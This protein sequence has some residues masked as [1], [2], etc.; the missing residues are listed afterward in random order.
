[1][2]GRYTL[3]GTRVFAAFG[4][5][6]P[7]GFE[8][9]YNIAPG[10]DCWVLTREDAW[11]ARRMRW[12]LVPHWAKDP[13]IGWKT[14]NARSETVAG[15][16][17][18]RDAFRKTR[19]VVPT[20]GFYEWPVV[21]ARRGKV[22]MVFTPEGGPRVFAGL[23][24]RWTPEGGAPL[25]TFTIVTAEAPPAFKTVHERCPVLLDREAADRWTDPAAGTETLK[26]LL[27]PFAPGT[28]KG[29]EVSTAVN[30]ASHDAPDC[31]TP[32][33]PFRWP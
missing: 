29:V 28:L 27:A 18:F 6:P 33:G 3:I 9:H 24:S 10:Q 16:P 12:G 23:W 15:K 21:A 13:A 4:L 8:P 7:A 14:I 17:A 32:A 5:E 2:C 25:D 19:C 1:M 30:R 11:S 26:A 22:P 20:D 31:V